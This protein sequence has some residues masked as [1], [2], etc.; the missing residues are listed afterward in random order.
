MLRAGCSRACTS[1]TAAGTCCGAVPAG[2]CLPRMR[3]RWRRLLD[4]RRDMVL[5]DPLAAAQEAVT[6]L[7]AVVA[8]KGGCTFIADPQGRAWSCDHGNV[9]LATSGSGDTLAGII[10]GLLAR[11]AAPTEATL[12]GVYLHA[13]AGMR[14]PGRGD[15][16]G[17]LRASYWRRS[18]ASWPT[19]RS[20]PRCGRNTGLSD[21]EPTCVAAWRPWSCSL[22]CRSPAA[23]RASPRPRSIPP[24]SQRPARRSSQPHPPP[25]W[26]TRPRR[27]WPVSPSA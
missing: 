16:S 1:S 13:E 24:G 15:R 17:I 20:H 9:G 22:R 21:T 27:C 2:S 26:P 5:A 23:A 10:A 19:C 12:W 7:Q 6:R 8:M 4:I 11:G 18:R 14:L 25:A 3:A